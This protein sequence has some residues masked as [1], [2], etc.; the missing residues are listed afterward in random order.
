MGDVCIDFIFLFCFR[1]DDDDDD[2]EDRATRQRASVSN[3]SFQADVRAWSVAGSGGKRTRCDTIRV[4]NFVRR[5]R[6]CSSI[7]VLVTWLVA[8][9]TS[10][11]TFVVDESEVE[12]EGEEDV[13]KDKDDM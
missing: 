7:N 11:S 8:W 3:C 5:R 1:E 10:P 12:D 13:D 9:S 4:R 2:D 6:R